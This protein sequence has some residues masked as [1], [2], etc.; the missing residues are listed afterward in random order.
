M[1]DNNAIII[2]EDNAPELFTIT[3]IDPRIFNLT[4]VYFLEDVYYCD[5]S[6]YDDTDYEQFGAILQDGGWVIPAYLRFNLLPGD[7]FNIFY[8]ENN[9]AELPFVHI[10][11]LAICIELTELGQM[12]FK[13]SQKYHRSF[14][15]IVQDVLDE[16]D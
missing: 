7:V 11:G 8:A 1:K 3:T 2:N 16:N 5:V 15:T 6:D 12:C 9:G 14:E 10:D 4:N 13:E